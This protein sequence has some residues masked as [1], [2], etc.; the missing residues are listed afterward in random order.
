MSRSVTNPGL[1]PE[2]TAM[3]QSVQG[4]LRLLLPHDILIQRRLA[5][6]YTRNNIEKD[7][8]LQEGKQ[9]I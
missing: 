7:R 5:G 9:A 2:V 3:E 6:V 1:A 8:N 4:P